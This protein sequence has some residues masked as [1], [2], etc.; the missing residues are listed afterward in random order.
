MDKSLF[1]LLLKLNSVARIDLNSLKKGKL[2]NAILP[3]GEEYKA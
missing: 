1:K 2:G 3:N